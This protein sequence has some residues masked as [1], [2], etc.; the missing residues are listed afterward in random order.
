MTI[1]W[2]KVGLPSPPDGTIGNAD[3]ASRFNADSCA[4]QG[5]EYGGKRQH[6]A[7]QRKNHQGGL[8]GARFDSQR[9]S[10][11]SGEGEERVGC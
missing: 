6:T 7:R 5:D 3:P 2:M 9:A 8:F 10:E 1:V 4:S 11:Q